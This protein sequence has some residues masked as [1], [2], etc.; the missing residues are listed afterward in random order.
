MNE[1]SKK[2]LEVHIAV[3]KRNEARVVEKLEELEE[4]EADSRGYLEKLRAE[5]KEIED[6][7]KPRPVAIINI[8]QEATKADIGRVV[9]EALKAYKAE[10][11]RD[12]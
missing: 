9:A 1:T 2:V 7:I 4:A 3:L 8:P 12:E 10:G 6:A 11:G 5:I